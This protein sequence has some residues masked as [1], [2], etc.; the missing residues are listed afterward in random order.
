MLPCRWSSFQD[1][2]QGVWIS[3]ARESGADHY[4]EEY[5]PVILTAHLKC[6]AIF[7]TEGHFTV[8]KER[9]LC[10]HV[11]IACTKKKIDSM[12]YPVPLEHLLQMW[13]QIV[14]CGNCW[15]VGMKVF[16]VVWGWETI[17]KVSNNLKASKAARVV[18]HSQTLTQKMG[19][20]QLVTL[21][22][23]V[24]VVCVGN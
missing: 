10:L 9:Q 22:Y 8:C 17:I 12:E 4:W 13:E 7:D 14:K 11:P 16:L 23:W 21:A 5:K 18:S 1:C 20:N 6:D 3:S 15:E 2:Y 24:G 19:E